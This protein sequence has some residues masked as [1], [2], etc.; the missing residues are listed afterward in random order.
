M[1]AVN[2]SFLSEKQKWIDDAR[3]K[4]VP[5]EKDNCIVCGKYLILTQAHHVI[6]LSYQFD[7]G[8]KNAFHYCVWLCPTHHNMVHLLMNQKDKWLTPQEC[9]VV[10]LKNF[11]LMNA[12]QKDEYSKVLELTDIDYQEQL[13]KQKGEAMLAHADALQCHLISRSTQAAA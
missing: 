12:I 2:Q 10:S 13:I 6:P 11:C 8:I 3:N 5:E 1:N 9:D 7:H 4:F